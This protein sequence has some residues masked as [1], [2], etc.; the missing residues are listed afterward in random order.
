MAIYQQ[1]PK[2]TAIL[3]SDAGELK[4]PGMQFKEFAA[5]IRTVRPF[6]R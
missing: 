1:Q 3:V 5:K 6:P 2:G 4:R